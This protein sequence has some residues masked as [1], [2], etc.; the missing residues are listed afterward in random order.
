MSTSMPRSIAQNTN[1][2][3]QRGQIWL[4]GGDPNNSEAREILEVGQDEIH[5]IR[6]NDEKR[7]TKQHEP[8]SR[9]VLWILR[10]KAEEVSTVL[11]SRGIEEKGPRTL[12]ED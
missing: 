12:T 10:D 7:K 9:F 5:Y 8:V 11:V 1:P 6:P 2:P 3:L 4:P